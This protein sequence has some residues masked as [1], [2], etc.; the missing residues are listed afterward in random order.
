[1]LNHPINEDGR[2]DGHQNYQSE[3]QDSGHH[4]NTLVGSH[5]SA[6]RQEVE[7]FSD[8]RGDASC[9]IFRKQLRRPGSLSVI[10]VAQRLIVAAV[11]VTATRPCSSIYHSDCGAI[12]SNISA[13]DSLTIS[14]AMTL[15][16]CHGSNEL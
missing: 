13:A 12:D 5:A 7:E 2:G 14:R 16:S 1:L 15:P 3:P 4:C 6:P 11:N 10:D 9:L 8:V